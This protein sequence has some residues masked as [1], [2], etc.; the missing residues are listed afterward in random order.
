MWLIV[1]LF[2]CSILQLY[3]CYNFVNFKSFSRFPKIDA[4]G[5]FKSSLDVDTKSICLTF[6]VYLLP[7][8][9]LVIKLKNIVCIYSNIIHCGT[10]SS[11]IAFFL[12]VMKK[13][14]L[15]LSVYFLGSRNRLM[16][17]VSFKTSH[18]HKFSSTKICF[19]ISLSFCRWGRLFQWPSNYIC[20][21]IGSVSV[22]YTILFFCKYDDKT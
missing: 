20:K 10:T 16:L 22:E 11:W 12:F 5:A 3:C 18:W 1:G 6:L 9:S 4:W 15:P 19:G 2:N 17:W 14:F 8:Y 21:L 7:T 13:G